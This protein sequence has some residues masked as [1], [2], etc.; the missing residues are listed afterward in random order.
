MRGPKE[1]GPTQLGPEATVAVGAARKPGGD[2]HSTILGFLI[3]GN[4][5]CLGA[6]C[7]GMLGL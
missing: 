7:Q 5:T 2:H 4:C 1:I 3:G 6:S